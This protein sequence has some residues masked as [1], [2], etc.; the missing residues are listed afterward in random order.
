[1]SDRTISVFGSGEF[2]PW[3]VE[4]DQAALD[5]ATSGDGSVVVVPAASAPEGNDVFDEWARK[6]VAHY[7]SMGVQ[8][9]VSALKS[10]ADAHSGEIIAQ[11]EGAS[12]IYFSG[13]NPAYLADILRDTPMW[14]AIVKAVE[15]GMSLAGCSA[16]ACFL[17]EV[18][19]DSG[20]DTLNPESWA[21]QGLRLLP[22]VAFGPHWDMIDTW[23]P[24]AKEFILSNIPDGVKFV[25]IDENTAALGNGSSW[26]AFGAGQITVRQ[27]GEESGPY[28]AGDTFD[29]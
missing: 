15:D 16:G 23:I 25:S 1:M 5:R 11:L 22:D 8:S 28:R 10:R 7:E 20:S 26:T 21:A 24:G 4:V 13:G 27:N 12:F 18:A 3:S 2:E 9:R 17:G 14:A 29:F 19:P 6:G